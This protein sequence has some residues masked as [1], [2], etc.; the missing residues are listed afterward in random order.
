NAHERARPGG[1]DKPGLDCEG[2]D[3]CKHVA[4]VRRIVDHLSVGSHLSEEIIDIRPVHAGGT[5]DGDLRCYRISAADPV[6]LERVAGAHD[7][8]E[9]GIALF[10][11]GRKIGSKK[12]RTARRASAHQDA[13]NAYQIVH[14]LTS[15]LHNP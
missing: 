11:V 8:Q 14:F 6:D 5:D 9:Y 12:E 4:A 3:G 15:I 1:L 7:G 13:W 2:P 10:T